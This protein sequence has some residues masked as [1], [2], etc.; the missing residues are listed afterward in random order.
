MDLRQTNEWAGYMTRMGWRVEYFRGWLAYLR[1]IPLTP[2][3]ILKIQRVNPK[4]I[5][6]AWVE[7]LEKKYRVITTYIEPN[8]PME[9]PGFHKTWNGMLP[10]KSWIL[11]LGLSNQDLLG[12]MKAKT[13]YNVKLAN[14]R[15][16]S[17]RSNTKTS[18]EFERLLV[19]NER[20][21]GLF[22]MGLHKIRAEVEAFRERV[23][24]IEVS[25]NDDLLAGA[26]FLC[27]KDAA[28]YMQNGSTQVGRKLMAPTLVVWEGIKEA[29]RR[30]L[31]YFDFDGVSDEIHPI[32]RWLGFTR[33][34]EGF[35][36]KGVHYPQALVKY[37][38]PF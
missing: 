22:G 26:I 23:F 38:W 10:T 16:F 30:G 33:F 2:F 24:T 4:D 15:Q 28:Y 21:V 9:I 7:K 19:G 35:G 31:K 6:V 27:T 14:S 32:K 5:D 18:E 34:K 36:G 13:R 3:S 25:K 20:R 37:R 8:K 12:Q 29:K 1:K 17:V 11:D